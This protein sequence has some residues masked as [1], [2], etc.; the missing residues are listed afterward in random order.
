MGKGI[1]QFWLQIR[2]PREE[3]YLQSAE[4]VQAPELDPIRNESVMS[5]HM[6]PCVPRKVSYLRKFVLNL[7][8]IIFSE[9]L[10]FWA[11]VVLGTGVSGPGRSSGSGVPQLLPVLKPSTGP[12]KSP[13]VFALTI[14]AKVNTSW[15]IT[16]TSSF[17]ARAAR[18]A[19]VF[20]VLVL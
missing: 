2:F 4:H 8:G 10:M 5:D 17:S 12:R 6:S 13:P 7:P 14:S 20:A 19:I 16:S 1:C 15:T 11:S 3:L 18:P 9:S